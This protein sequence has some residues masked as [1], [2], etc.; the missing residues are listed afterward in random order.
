ME[1]FQICFI[2]WK[3]QQ[4]SLSRKFVGPSIFDIFNVFSFTKKFTRWNRNRK[5]ENIKFANFLRFLAPLSVIINPQCEHSMCKLENLIFPLI[6]LLWKNREPEEKNVVSVWPSHWK[7]KV[8][9]E[10]ETTWNLIFAL[11]FFYSLLTFFSDF[12]F[13]F[14]TLFSTHM[15]HKISRNLFNAISS[16]YL[17]SLLRCQLK[18]FIFIIH[19]S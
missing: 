13:F 19:E 4:N 9:L 8:V 10:L 12:S 1:K 6:F 15:K 5:H 16:S 18:C 2:L 3:A 11:L 17:L 14:L 7:R